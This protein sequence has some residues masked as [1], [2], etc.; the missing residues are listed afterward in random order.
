[1]DA[2]PGTKAVTLDADTASH[3]FPILPSQQ[4][5]FIIM[6]NKFF[7]IDSCAPFGA[8][9]FSGSGVFDQIANALIAL[10]KAG[11]WKA[12]KK[13]VSYF[14]FFWYPQSSH[15][16]TYTYTK[17]LNVILLLV[18]PLGWPWKPSKKK[19]LFQTLSLTLASNGA[20]QYE[21]LQSQK[22]K[23]VKF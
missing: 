5:A 8:M 1:M 10:Y 18:A 7:Y 15:N 16:G 22:N 13:W 3:C 2:P 9:S 6:W 14:L 21:W 19:N 4:H 17:S 12:V 23:C 20:Y 11:G